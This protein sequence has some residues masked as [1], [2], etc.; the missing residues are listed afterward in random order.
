MWF[1]KRDPLKKLQKN[2]ER[3]MREARD[4]QRNGDIQA[5]AAKVDEA[6]KIAEQIRTLETTP[7]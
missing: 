4:I 6:E 7:S 3:L 1:L 5:Y 2:Y